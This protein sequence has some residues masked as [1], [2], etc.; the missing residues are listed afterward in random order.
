[1]SRLDEFLTQCQPYCRDCGRERDVDPAMLP[2][3]AD[4]PVPEIGKRMRCSVCGSR[5][6]HT[7]P[8]LYPDLWRYRHWFDLMRLRL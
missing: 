3:P 6:I 7:A 1:M 2:L 8:E 5:K 4:C